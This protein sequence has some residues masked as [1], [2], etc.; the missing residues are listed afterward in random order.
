MRWA[1]ARPVASRVELPEAGQR[2]DH[3]LGGEVGAQRAGG[4]VRPQQAVEGF[5]DRGV[6]VAGGQIAS[7]RGGLAQG[8]GEAVLGHR[9]VR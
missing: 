6:G 3:V 9:V 2:E 7:G 8:V 4:D 5:D 1:C